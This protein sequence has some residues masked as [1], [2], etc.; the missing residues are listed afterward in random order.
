M[1][2]ILITLLSLLFIFAFSALIAQD[3]INGQDPDDFRA[4]AAAEKNDQSP[5]VYK[6]VD[7]KVVQLQPVTGSLTLR[8]K[9]KLIEI[10]KA[11]IEAQKKSQVPARPVQKDLSARP[12][13]TG[14]Q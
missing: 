8:D 3:G 7:G 2:K 10:T 12:Q 1:R 4:T 11:R 13:R 6:M 9:Q 14:S 5:Q